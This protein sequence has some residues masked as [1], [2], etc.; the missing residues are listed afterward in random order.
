MIFIFIQ[1]LFSSKKLRPWTTNAAATTTTASSITTTP[2]TTIQPRT[3]TP[4]ESKWLVGGSLIPFHLQHQPHQPPTSHYDS[5]G[6][7]SPSTCDASHINPQ[8]V[9]LTRWG[10]SLPLHLQRQPQWPPTS[11]CDSGIWDNRVNYLRRRHHFTHL[12]QQPHFSHRCW[13]RWL[14]RFMQ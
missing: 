8:R 9:I 1:F 13:R 3:T 11:H 2:T 7:L 12:C 6:A 10:L 4:N 5:L 14:I